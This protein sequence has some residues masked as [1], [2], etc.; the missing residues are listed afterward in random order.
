L[1]SQRHAEP[2]QVCG[3]LAFQAT[4]HQSRQ[5]RLVACGR[6]NIGAGGEVVV[7]NLAD[8]SGVFQEQLR[9]PERIAQVG[10]A[11][12]QLG[13]QRAVEDDDAFLFKKWREGIHAY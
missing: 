12:F 2:E 8:Q 1:L 3:F 4:L 5:C 9:R 7:M 13:R 6:G 10:A 11:L